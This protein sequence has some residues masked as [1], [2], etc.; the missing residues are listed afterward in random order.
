MSG[1]CLSPSERG[2][3]LTPRTH[4][5]LGEPLPHQLANRTQ[6]PPQAESHLWSK[7]VIWYYFR[8]PGAIPVLR[9]GNYVLLSLSPLSSPLREILARLACLIHAANVHS[10]PGSNPSI[11]YSLSTRISPSDFT[12]LLKSLSGKQTSILASTSELNQKSITVS[13]QF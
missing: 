3:A 10:E 5:C 1:Q 13:I 6:S 4:Q 7:D 12:S 11:F 2:H 8:F 9:V